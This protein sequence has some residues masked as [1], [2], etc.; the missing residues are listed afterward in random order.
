MAISDLYVCMCVCVS[1]CM[2]VCVC[3]CVCVCQSSRLNLA[4]HITRDPDLNP[5]PTQLIYMVGSCHRYLAPPIQRCI[6]HIVCG[7]DDVLLRTEGARRCGPF[8]LF[9]LLPL[10]LPIHSPRHVHTS[11]C[12]RFLWVRRAKSTASHMSSTTPT[13]CSLASLFMTCA[14]IHSLAQ[15]SRHSPPC[16]LQVLPP[17]KYCL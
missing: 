10:L 4:V 3:V 7:Y 14:S 5:R 16:A 12:G 1:P 8:R 13:D 6:Q 15:P 2:H 11:G 17:D 9:L